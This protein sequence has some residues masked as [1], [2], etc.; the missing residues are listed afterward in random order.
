MRRP[1]Y[2]P[3]PLTRKVVLRNPK[4]IPDSARDSYGRVTG[5]D[6]SWGVTVFASRRDGM[7]ETL[8]E[9]GVKVFASGTVW[10]IRER[11]GVDADVEVVS[12]GIVYRSIGPPRLMGGAPGG[13]LSRYFEIHTERRE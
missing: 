4:D 9:E 5:N 6:P 8:Y 12:D 11:S 3:P 10:T 2:Y 1:A 7:P 13:R